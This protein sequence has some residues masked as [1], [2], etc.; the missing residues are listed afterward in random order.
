MFTPVRRDLFRWETPDPES[1]W[2]MVGHFIARDSGCVLVDPPLVPG[3]LE[4][5]KRIGK[6]EGVVLTT[7]DHSRGAAYIAKKTG[8]RLYVPD[9]SPDDID[10]RALRILK[11]IADHERYGSGKVLGL[12]VFRLSVPENRDIGM[13]SMNEFALLT[14]HKELITGDFVC[15]SPE[16]RILVAPEWFPTETPSSAYPLAQTEFRSLVRKAEAVSLLSSHG[17]DIIGTLQKE[18]ERF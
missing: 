15:G 14:D 8:A 18:L 4:A 13:P 6:V 10:P 1:D 16:G 11:E 9:Q 17:S 3:L 2:M 7:L 5:V 12:K